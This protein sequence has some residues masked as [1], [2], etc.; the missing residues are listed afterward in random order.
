MVQSPETLLAPHLTQSPWRCSAPL[1]MHRERPVSGAR[2]QQRVASNFQ[3]RSA[4][5]AEAGQLSLCC[6]GEELPLAQSI[7][8]WPGVAERLTLWPLIPSHS[9]SVSQSCPYR[10]G[11]VPPQQKLNSEGDEGHLCLFSRPSPNMTRSSSPLLGPQPQLYLQGVVQS[12]KAAS[13][14]T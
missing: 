11:G 14:Q 3:R 5:R 10:C 8:L 12:P 13:E 4:Q 2:P 1:G 6:Q 7:C 9:A